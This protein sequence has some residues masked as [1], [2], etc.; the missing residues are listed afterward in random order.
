MAWARGRCQK[1]IS[2]S[3][4]Q[5]QNEHQGRWIGDP[6]RMKFKVWQRD[7]VGDVRYAAGLVGKL[8]G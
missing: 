6:G 8:N 2:V 4:E 5:T 1:A 3:V 7:A